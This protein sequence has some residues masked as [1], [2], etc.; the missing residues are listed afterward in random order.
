MK[1]EAMFLGGPYSGQ[2]YRIPQAER[3]HR[4]GYRHAHYLVNV[5]DGKAVHCYLTGQSRTTGFWYLRYQD[6]F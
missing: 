5:W 1:V 6:S 3:P 2:T 4:F